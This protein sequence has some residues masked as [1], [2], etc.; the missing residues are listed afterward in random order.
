MGSMLGGS[1]S[2]SSQ[3]QR[4]TI[5]PIFKPYIMAA[6]QQASDIANRP[7]IPYAGQQVASLNPDQ[8][9]GI[10]A[11]RRLASRPLA[12]GGIVRTFAD[13]STTTATNTAATPAGNYSKAQQAASFATQ[14]ALNMQNYTPGQVSSNYTAGSY[15]PT[16][17]TSLTVDPGTVKTFSMEPATQVNA[18][19]TKVDPLTTFKMGDVPA[20][21]AA[22]GQN[23]DAARTAGINSL[24]TNVGPLTTYSMANVPA[25]TAAT[26]RDIDAVDVADITAQQTK[27]PM[28]GTQA[29]INA[30]MDPYTQ[31]VV[32]IAKQQA[33][34][35][36]AK[37][38]IVRMGQATQAGA[39][40]G[41]RQG[42]E[43][44]EAS[45]VLNEQLQNIQMQGQQQAYVAGQ[46]Q[47][48]KDVANLMATGQF[49]AQQAN[50]IAQQNQQ[51]R[52]QTSLANQQAALGVQQQNV[53][54]R[55]AAEL[56]NQQAGLTTAQQNL[57][58]QQ[59]T[60][61]LGTQT[62]LQSDLANQQADLEAQ[63]ASQQAELQ[64]NLANQQGRLNV[65][66]QTVANK[67]A[68]ELANQQANLTAAQQ[69][70]ASQQATQQLG[71]QTKAQL[72]LANQQADLEAQRANQQAKLTV[73]EQNLAAQQAAQQLGITSLLQAQQAN[74]QANLEAQRAAEQSKQFEFTGEQ[75][76]QQQAAQMA[77]QAGQENVTN[78][79][80]ARQQGLG[81]LQTGLQGAQE[82]AGIETALRNADIQSQQNLM[83]AGQMQQQNQQQLLD[84]NAQNWNNFQNF[85][86]NQ[87]NKLLGMLNTAGAQTFTTQQQTA[88]PTKPSA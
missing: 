61:Q 41:Y 36:A 71:T 57:A 24:T 50:Q 51:I 7:Y 16:G 78:A 53:S 49:N 19:T 76:A 2:G 62:K 12:V 44:S 11:A 15:T 5:D 35:D 87:L 20:A 52:Q 64:T 54:N 72:D 60:Q 26:G 88:N 30:Y 68:A 10:L 37:Q 81:A 63:R 48:N 32:D 31:G 4:N 69:N 27:Q 43:E 34:R 46:E 77:M 82:M 8:Y 28:L 9:Q 85:D 33:I 21:N 29:N 66:Q 1:V 70:L 18:L 67:Q 13:G 79:L 47:F 42:I 40:G 73:G 86:V 55:Q 84:T 39:F 56:A 80:A 23:I 65:Q 22:A 74:Q 25:A 59:A 3:T 38:H 17:F 6:L 75:S 45:R 14:G 83:A 58:S